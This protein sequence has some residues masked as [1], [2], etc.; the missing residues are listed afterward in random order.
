M[1]APWLSVAKTKARRWRI[2]PHASA[3]AVPL[4]LGERNSNFFFNIK[5]IADQYFILPLFYLNYYRHISF[6]ATAQWLNNYTHYEML[7]TVSVV[8]RFQYF[9][10]Y[11]PCFIFP[12]YHLLV[13]NTLYT[14]IYLIYGQS[15]SPEYG[16]RESK[17]FVW[18]KTIKLY[19][20]PYRKV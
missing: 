19:Y 5:F 11:L 17:N 13:F 14:L 4:K 7:T 6:R 8:T 10:F 12:P 9:Y 3:Q 20:F 1:P 18:T 2:Q 16:L 15:P